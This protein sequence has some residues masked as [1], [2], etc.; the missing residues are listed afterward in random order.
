MC[1]VCNGILLLAL[2]KILWERTGCATRIGALAEK[3]Q[4]KRLFRKVVPDA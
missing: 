1:P 4:I 3:L 2:A